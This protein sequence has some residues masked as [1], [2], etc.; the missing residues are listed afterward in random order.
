LQVPCP[1]NV[2]GHMQFKHHAVAN[3]RVLAFARAA[4]TLSFWLLYTK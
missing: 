4:F 3:N 1:V 2:P